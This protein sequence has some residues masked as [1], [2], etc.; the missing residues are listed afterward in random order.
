MISTRSSTDGNA[1]LRGTLWML[2]LSLLLFWLPLFGP[3]IAG[4]V[5]GRMIGRAGSAVL[6]ALVPAIAVGALAVLVLSLF[7]LPIVGAIA[8][9]G[10]FV[11]VAVQDV[12]LILGAWAG[13]ALD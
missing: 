3:L 8:G 13:A 9:L 7:D 10:V 11:A 5:G 1:V 6:V 4:F 12:P 2:G